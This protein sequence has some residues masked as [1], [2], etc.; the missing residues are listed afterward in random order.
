VPGTVIGETGVTFDLSVRESAGKNVA[1]P[2]NLITPPK[3]QA[4][5]RCAISEHPNIVSGDL[6]GQV[7]CRYKHPV[8]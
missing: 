7:S 8:Q 1:M 3:L 5:S 2:T 4:G 6:A